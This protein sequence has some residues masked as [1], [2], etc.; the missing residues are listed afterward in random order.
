MTATQSITVKQ[1]KEMN[2]KGMI[3]YPYPR[4]GRI[5]INGGASKPATK[6]ALKEARRFLD[7]QK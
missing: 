7:S 5:A 2:A 4:Q 1:V 3:V 6:E